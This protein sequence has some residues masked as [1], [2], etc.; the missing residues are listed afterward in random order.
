MTPPPDQHRALGQ[1]AWL[2]DIDGTLLTTDGASREAF[3]A[4][5]RD[6][7]GVEHDLRDVPFA[8]RTEPLIL[9]DVLMA[10]GRRMESSAEQRA[11]WDRVIANMERLLGPT[12]GRLLPGVV[13]ALDALD[14]RAVG[15]LTGNMTAMAQVKLA[16]FGI[17]ERFHFGSFG[18]EAT[19]RN[20]LACLAVKRVEERYGIPA[21]HCIVIGDTEHDVACARAA[22][23]RAV[24]VGTGQRRMDVLEAAAPDLLI[25]DLTR[26]DDVLRWAASLD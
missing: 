6:C 12:R 21:A 16:R 2:F 18:E 15:L 1:L 10:I 11:F 14:G 17:R 24:A 7:F 3:S 22:G 5:V 4:A 19:D 25:A 20:A 23:A 26:F 8:G 9:A 13:E